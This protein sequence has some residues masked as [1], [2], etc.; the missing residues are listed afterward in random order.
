MGA[1]VKRFVYGTVAL[2]IFASVRVDAQTATINDIK[3]RIFDA[4][5][6]E[7]TFANGLKF[8]RELDGTNFFFAPRNRVLNLED[9]HRSLENL[10]REHVFNPEKR[11]PWNEDDA[12]V[13]WA[14]VQQEA[15]TDKANCEL[16][17]SLPALEKQLQDLEKGSEAAKKN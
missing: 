9:Y 11:R 15:L 10:A 17:A 16:V 3:G 14:Q 1:D 5:M 4:H 8:C 2:A 12:G 6:M 7:K 13:R